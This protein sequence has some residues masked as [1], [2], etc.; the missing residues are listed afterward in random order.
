VVPLPPAAVVIYRGMPTALLATP[1]VPPVVLR[2]GPRRSLAGWCLDA[3]AVVGPPW[4]G[5]PAR[6]PFSSD[7]VAQVLAIM[8]VDAGRHLRRPAR[9][10][11]PDAHAL[12][13]AGGLLHGQR[14]FTGQTPIRL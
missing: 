10:H 7:A 14:P 11:R 2:S 4:I 1:S 9:L 5:P 8:S 3:G 12:I 6:P 13:A